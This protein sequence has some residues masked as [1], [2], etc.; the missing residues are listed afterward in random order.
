[1]TVHSK[2]DAICKGATMFSFKVLSK[3]LPGQPMKN[4]E[5]LS[6]VSRYVTSKICGVLMEKSEEKWSLLI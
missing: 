2:L 4:H 5:I 3:H 6:Q 1:M